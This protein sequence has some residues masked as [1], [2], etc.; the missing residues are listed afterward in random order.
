MSP[1]PGQFTRPGQSPVRPY[2]PQGG[3]SRY[4]PQYTHGGGHLA[5]A[6]SDQTPGSPNPDRN[7]Y[8]R[9]SSNTSSNHSV[10]P[11]Y[12]EV[13]RPSPV[14]SGGTPSPRPYSHVGNQSAYSPTSPPGHSAY[15]HLASSCDNSV[16][17]SQDYNQSPQNFQPVNSPS[18]H[19]DQLYSNPNV[20]PNRPNRPHDLSSYQTRQHESP[21]S[22]QQHSYGGRAGHHGNSRYGYHDYQQGQMSAHNSMPHD[23]YAEYR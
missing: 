9:Q 3:Q 8:R 16:Q 1:K 7:V 5:P 14:S 11:G 6:R 2:S 20:G 18:Y 12:H 23:S 10:S 13:S 17:N 19:R 21:P 22:Q 15:S 4:S